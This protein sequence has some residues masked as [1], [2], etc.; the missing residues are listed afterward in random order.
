MLSAA[1]PLLSLALTRVFP[2]L[3]FAGDTLSELL[4]VCL[5]SGWS[6]GVV[7]LVATKLC[8]R[9]CLLHNVNPDNI[10]PTVVTT[11]GDL[12]TL[13]ALLAA[14]LLVRGT[15]AGAATGGTVGNVI[16]IVVLVVA[17][18]TLAASLRHALPLLRRIV[19]ESLPVLA[20]ASFIS[21]IA[22]IVVENQLG[23]FLDQPALLVLVPA[24]FGMAGALGGILS[25]RLGSK[26]H[27]GLIQSRAFPQREAWVDIRSIAVLAGPIFVLVGLA[28]HVGALIVGATSP[29]VGTMVSIALLAGFGATIVVLAVAYYGTLGAVRIGL[30]PDTA[31]IPLTNS[32][33]DLVGAFTLV[34]AIILLGVGT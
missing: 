8:V 23:T 15:G 22:G 12:V 9:Y 4:V 21:L 17:A 18:L 30:D 10:A 24:Y 34:G 32:V 6:C 13:P 7:M 29:G 28:A 20:A 2:S 5:V 27:L 16:G 31:T 1:L 11:V 25:S 33:L 19:I 3:P 26:V 14:S